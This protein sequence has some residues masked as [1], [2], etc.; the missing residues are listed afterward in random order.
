MTIPARPNILRSSL[1]GSS[2]QYQPIRFITTYWPHQLDRP[3]VSRVDFRRTRPKILKTLLRP[4]H[5]DANRTPDSSI[6]PQPQGS[7]HS[8]TQLANLISTPRRSTEDDYSAPS[9]VKPIGIKISQSAIEQI[10]RVRK[11]DNKPNEVLRLSV[12][13]GGCHGF[14]YKIAFT[15]SVEDDDFVF[16]NRSGLVV[17][18]EG[19]L[20]LMDGSTIEFATELIGS[21]FRILDNPHSAGKGCGCG[22]SW[23]LK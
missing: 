12:E 13:S 16:G 10:E 6:Q 1:L 20:S 17:I 15:E 9:I 8:P 21:S 5:Q 4:V 2:Y 7:S 22:V 19:S 14:Q 23:E 18:D 11:M 3:D